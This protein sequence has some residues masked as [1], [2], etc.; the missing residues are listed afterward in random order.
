MRIQRPRPL[1]R[2]RP[3]IERAVSA[4]G[5]LPKL[6]GRLDQKLLVTMRTKGHNDLTE[7]IAGGLGTFGEWGI[8]WLGVAAAGALL[9][10]RDRRDAWLSAV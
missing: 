7:R 5:G 6:L 9:R 1:R 3:G 10:G 8:G 2:D 4:R